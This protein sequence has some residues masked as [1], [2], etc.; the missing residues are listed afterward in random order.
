MRFPALLGPKGFSVKTG[1][2][3]W[4]SC[5]RTWELHF[6]NDPTILENLLQVKGRQMGLRQAQEV[7]DPHRLPASSCHLPSVATEL[8]DSAALHADAFPL[9][10]QGVWPGFLH[11]WQCVKAG[12]CQT[13]STGIQLL[14]T[15]PFFTVILNSYL[16]RKVANSDTLSFMHKCPGTL[17][18][19]VEC[20]SLPALT[21]EGL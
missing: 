5:M 10:S 2:L 13:Q 8:G 3:D 12:Q 11:G 18:N 1:G 15:R 7:P 4:A 19:C 17:S 16:N 21:C 6:P 14:G 20:T 9:V